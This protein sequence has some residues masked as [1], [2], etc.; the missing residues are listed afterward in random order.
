MKIVGLFSRFQAE[1]PASA[2][3]VPIQYRSLR[4]YDRLPAGTGAWLMPR[5]GGTG[6]DGG[7]AVAH[8][9]RDNGMAAI[10]PR[11]FSDGL[12][13]LPM[14]GVFI[15][16]RNFLFVF[17]SP[18]RRRSPPRLRSVYR[19]G[20]VLHSPRIYGPA[21]RA[22]RALTRFRTLKLDTLIPIATGDRDFYERNGER[23]IIAG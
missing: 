16:V 10:N 20:K 3:R 18:S 22:S 15:F 21:R 6:R 4:R 14:F 9:G 19:R 5:A 1:D 7:A 2:A 12:A 13:P 23:Q 11:I 17:L 8:A